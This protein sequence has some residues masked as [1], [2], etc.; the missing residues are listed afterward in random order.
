LSWSCWVFQTKQLW[1]GKLRMAQTEHQIC[2]FLK[3]NPISSHTPTPSSRDWKLPPM[4]NGLGRDLP[5]LTAWSVNNTRH[6]TF[7]PKPWVC[8]KIICPKKY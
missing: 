3:K 2:V 5:H 1:G 4:I 7:N 8:V 6:S